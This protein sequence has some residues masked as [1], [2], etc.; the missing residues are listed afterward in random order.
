MRKTI[1]IGSGLGGL[2]LAVRLQSAG[3]STILIE[4]N[5]KFGGYAYVKC[6]KKFIFDMGPTIIT[7]P[8][9][10]KELF[11]LTGKIFSNYITLI[12]VKPFYRICW[13][14]G[15][16][17]EYSN[18]RKL[19]DKQI[20]IFNSYDI[21][22]YK[23]FLKYSYK[24]FKLGYLKLG[25]L[26]CFS[27][28]NLIKYL[29]EMIKLKAWSSIYKI[30]SN[31]IR[32]KNLR[33]AF[34]FHSLLIGGNPFTTSSI[35]TLIHALEHEWGIW[36]PKGGINNL[37]NGI[38]KLYCDLGGKI[39]LNTKVVHIE[40]KKDKINKVKLS[41]G[42]IYKVNSVA[43]NADIM[44]TYSKLLNG[45]YYSKIRSKQ[46][47]K[48]KMSN[49]LFIVYFG[50]SNPH[51]QLAQ[52]T[53]CF[54]LR[55]KNLLNDIFYKNKIK[56]DFSLYLHSPC[57][58]DKSMAPSNCGTFYALVPVPNLANSNINWD[59]EGPL[60]REKIFDYLEKNYMPNLRNQ[61]ITH[62]II[63]PFD[64][65][66]KFS[67]YHGSSFS[68]APLITQSAWFRPKNHDCKIKNLYL[69]GAG[70]HPGAGIPGV[71]SS[72]KI[73]AK[74]MIKENNI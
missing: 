1:I 6:K 57:A 64:F 27:F 72:A 66:N 24:T 28:I 47:K 11:N 67:S 19:L 32:D 2:A 54:G 46:L 17:I 12:P 29:P 43:S 10:I 34:S 40:I 65:K 48:M 8:Y 33:Q 37:I 7:N 20:K 52:H 35:Y 59:I 30:I 55:Y 5:K 60:F 44:N 39:I 38:S 23:K 49:S 4:K 68:I 63:T 21:Y 16:K 45:Y 73:T 58:T 70:T 61:L 22:G 62:H 25:C 18:N 53:I 3:F 42:K 51:K 13:Q 69:V 9:A 56:K 36:F 31:F 74:L 41:N 14:S 71:L 26:P 50:L 15:K